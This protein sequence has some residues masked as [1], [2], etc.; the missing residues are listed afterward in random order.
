[1]NLKHDVCRCFG[2]SCDEKDKCLRYLCRFTGDENT[3]K[4]ANGVPYD[5]LR[6]CPL[7]IISDIK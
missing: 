5:E 3:P 7:K 4:I 2:V 1:M 6:K